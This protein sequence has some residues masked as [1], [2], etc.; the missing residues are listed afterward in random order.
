MSKETRDPKSCAQ[1][2]LTVG[3]DQLAGIGSRPP[4]VLQYHFAMIDGKRIDAEPG[5]IF[6]EDAR[7]LA[8]G[9]QVV[10]EVTLGDHARFKGW[11]MEVTQ[12][13]RIVGTILCELDGLADQEN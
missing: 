8:Y 5:E 6:P 7:A 9:R 4:A 1:Q 11:A 13:T 3:Q 10:R 2:G 12:G